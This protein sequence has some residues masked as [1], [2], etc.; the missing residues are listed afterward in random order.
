[1]ASP[2]SRSTQIKVSETHREDD[3]A[4]TGQPRAGAGGHRRQAASAAA[5]GFP[6]RGRTLLWRLRGRGP[7]EALQ[8]SSGPAAAAGAAER[9]RWRPDAAP[10]H[11]GAVSGSSLSPAGPGPSPG[12]RSGRWRSC[13]GQH[14]PVGGGRGEGQSED[15]R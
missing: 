11:A 8:Q 12:R 15:V 5:A 6:R 7:D 9:A 1:M 14:W 3:Q 10:M 13:G 2:G 4:A